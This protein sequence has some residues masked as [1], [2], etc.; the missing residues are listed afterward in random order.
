MVPRR[1]RHHRRA[2][3]YR[4]RRADRT[5]PALAR[6]PGIRGL[7][8]HHRPARRALVRRRAPPPRA[9]S[10]CR[11]PRSLR[12]DEGPQG[13][14]R[15]MPPAGREVRDLQPAGVHTGGR[16]PR[17]ARYQRP[18]RRPAHTRP[19]PAPHDNTRHFYE[20]ARAIVAGYVA[21]VRFQEPVYRRTLKTVHE[22]LSASPEAREGF[23]E[24][25]RREEPFAGGLAH[26]A[27]ERQAQVGREEGG[28]N[29][30]T[31]A[32][33]LAFLNYP[34]LLRNTA[35][36][37][38]DPTRLAEGN[39][40]LFVVAPE[41]TVE[42]VKGWLRLWVAI[43][44]AVAGRTP[45]ER[46]MLIVIDEMP[47]HRLPQAGDGRLHH[48]RR[49]GC[50]LLVLRAVDLGSRL[51]LGQGAPQDPAAPRRA[52]AGAGLPAHRRGGRGRAVE[53]HRHRDLRGPDREPVGHHRREPRR[54]RQHALAGGRVALSGARAGW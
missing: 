11:A 4:Q 22:M 3:A 19:V 9:R 34:E 12:R 33:Q 42:H 44:N 47:P 51:E 17:R 41:E 30:T 16:Q 25:F 20:S 5:Q 46:D 6:R 43:P 54:H 48:G 45:L 21:W 23:A 8:R 31:V 39:T 10:R 52:G 24:A 53:G 26:I 18:A 32:N 29:F 40:D 28:S 38:F 7:D 1:L 50:P 13:C 14:V 35:R 49:Q 27:V 2:A 37:S 36:S 15:G